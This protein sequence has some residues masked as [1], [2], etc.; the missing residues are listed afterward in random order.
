MDIDNATP[1]TT[2]VRLNVFHGRTVHSLVLPPSTTLSEIQQELE[3]LTGVPPFN[4]KLIAPKRG[5]LKAADADSPISKLILDITKPT[6]VTMMGT[7]P[8][9]VDAIKLQ[10]P[11]SFK[12]PTP[13]FVFH[14]HSAVTG[15]S[16]S[17]EDA[18]IDPNYTFHKLVPLAFLPNSELALALLQRL[19]R[20]RGIQAIMRRHKWS[21]PV[22]TELDP[23]SNTSHDGK[24]LGL[25]RNKGQVIELRLRTDA[26]DGFRD[27]KTIRTTLCHELAHNEHSPGHDAGFWALFREL[28]REVIELDPFSRNGHALSKQE[29][30]QP[31]ESHEDEEFQ[32][33]GGWQGG[34]FVLGGGNAVVDDSATT[35]TIDDINR[36]SDRELTLRTASMRNSML[37]AALKR[38]QQSSS[39]KGKDHSG[40]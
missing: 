23:A 39:R 30:F 16:N 11:Q 28:E 24:L 5:L 27:Y 38:Q 18:N 32:D 15:G 4:Q 29:Y 25:N 14:D 33:N 19:R 17:N 26:Y 7:K 21:V 20:D 37:D 35:T 34:S 10:T 8:E 13:R 6:K 3:V 40:R 1:A 31:V 2:E 36:L 12:R 22:L 9:V